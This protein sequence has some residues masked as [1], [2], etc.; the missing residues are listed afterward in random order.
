[1]KQSNNVEI[2]KAYN[3]KEAEKTHYQLGKRTVVSRPKSMK[4]KRREL[5]N[6]HSAAECDG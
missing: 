3:P 5:F 6:R 4:I 2:A 1:M